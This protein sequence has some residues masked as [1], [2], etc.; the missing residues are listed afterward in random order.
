MIAMSDSLAVRPTPQRARTLHGILRSRLDLDIGHAHVG[1]FNRNSKQWQTESQREFL[2]RAAGCAMHMRSGGLV[3]GSA[4]ILAC[5]S[6][7]STLLGFFGAILANAIP[8]VLPL[9]PAFDSQ[10]VVANRIQQTRELLGTESWLLIESRNGKL[11][12]P[13]P[14]DNLFLEFDVSDMRPLQV[15]DVLPNE[16]SGAIS[17]IQL[18]SGSTGSGKGVAVT[19]ASLLANIDALRDRI[20]VNPYDVFISWLPLY[21]D[22]GLVSKAILPFV[23]GVDT[24]L[25]SP[26]DFL[27]E[28]IRWLEAISMFRGTVSAS[29]TFGYELVS[30][31]VRHEQLENIDLSSWK[32]AYCGAEPISASVMRAFYEKFA[33]SGLR[34]AAFTPSYGLAEA[35]LA[36]TAIHTEETSRTI[37]VTRKSLSQLDK[38]ELGS[39]DV[40]S[41][42][43]VA[44]GKPV[45]GLSVSLRDSGGNEV[46]GEL[47]CGEI[48][49][50]GTSVTDGWLE[51][52][53]VITPFAFDGLRTGDIGFFEN[54]ELFVVDRI[55][56]ILIRNGHNYSSLVLEQAIATLLEVAPEN[57]LVFDID[58]LRNSGLTAV[59]ETPRGVEPQILL[60]RIL[61]GLDNLELRP[62]QFVFVKHGSVERTTSGKKRHVAIR[63]A[64]RDGTL[65]NV[66]LRHELDHEHRHVVDL[67]D[68]HM[69]PDEL[70]LLDMVRSDVRRRGL[71]V[72]VSV[73]SH[74]TGDLD[75]DSLGIIELALRAESRFNVEL[76]Q[77]TIAEMKTVDDL[78]CAIRRTTHD[79]PFETGLSE[80]LKQLKK[81]VPQFYTTI[82]DVRPNREISVDG[83][84]MTDLSSCGYL[85][86]EDR[87]EVAEAIESAHR[88]W[89]LQRWSTRAVGAPVSV[90]QLEQRLASKIGAPDTMVFGTITLLHVGVLPIL[91]GQNGSI[92]IDSAAHTSM[93]EATA[94]ARGKGVTTVSFRHGDLNELEAKLQRLS[95]KSNR[96][97]ALDG[98]YSMSGALLRLDDYKKLAEKYDAWLYVDDA[99]GF[100]VIGEHPSPAHPLGHNGNGIVR[101]TGGNYDR[102]FYVG[103]LG[104]AYSTAMGLISCPSPEYRELFHNAFTSIFGHLTSTSSIAQA[105]A[106][107]DIDERDGEAIRSQLTALIRQLVDGAE[108]LGFQVRSRDSAIVNVIVGDVDSLITGTN[109]LWE[110]GIK[111]TP[112]MFPAVPLDEGGLRFTVTATN[113]EEQI[114]KVLTSLGRL[115]VILS[116]QKSVAR[117]P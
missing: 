109:V 47:T 103:G 29:P 100:G 18:T 30:S 17:H 44:L 36:V 107:L 1:F 21:H 20:E 72:E 81:R 59:I 16:P 85:G 62:E 53:G 14:S 10:D 69:S 28:P 70:E 92:L 84:W 89:G 26:F 99:H 88:H 64:L 111:I 86:L 95:D 74:L 54:E 5:S 23:L 90:R 2:M 79:G 56:N 94:L 38:I 22:M 25:M 52:G 8:V 68:D 39:N 41:V 33:A 71:T 63:N 58:V 115:K 102:I 98:V 96:I 50:N 4:V 67:R 15:I 77:R 104:K 116:E 13:R 57:V 40:D 65:R 78:L 112:A 45:K 108:N 117:Q 42:E 87:P 80:T 31:R 97:I 27:S 48:V 82:D 66:L 24:F 76:E 9:R 12:A 3:D 91:A 110:D 7:E 43:V 32:S 11:V 75:F 19:N 114:D 49:V 6:P 34:S 37:R 106:V 61:T 35:T 113:T 55:K 93:Q 60:Q 83:R 73:H 101:H 105:N 51:N 46:D